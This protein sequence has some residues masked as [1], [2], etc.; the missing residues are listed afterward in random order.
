MKNILL[1]LAIGMAFTLLCAAELTPVNVL[2]EVDQTL[3]IGNLKCNI[4]LKTTSEAASIKA[5]TWRQGTDKALI[6]FT[7]PAGERGNKLLKDGDSYW[8]YDAQ[9][10]RTER[11][12][13]GMLSQSIA[14]T[15]LSYADLMDVNHL[16]ESFSVVLSTE[17]KYK[18][19][20]CLL[21]T[22]TAK[23][24]ANPFPKAIVYVDKLTKLPVLQQYYLKSGKL[25]KVIEIQEIFQSAD[26]P[27]PQKILYTDNLRNGKGTLLIIDKIEYDAKIPAHIFSKA[28][29]KQ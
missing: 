15:D 27:Y 23:S 25:A 1:Y 5:T 3:P 4:T 2:A 17:T 16:A 10:D 14:G 11:F 6:E 29:L 12:A 18:K 13:T 22:L 24:P 20:D 7:E 8:L 19:Q 26:R 21:L 9:A 28:S